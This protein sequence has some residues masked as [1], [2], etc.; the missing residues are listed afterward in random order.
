[1]LLRSKTLLAKHSPQA[2]FWLNGFWED[3]ANKYAEDIW[4]FVSIMQELVFHL[5]KYVESGQRK[6]YGK[7]KVDVRREEG[8]DFDF[9]G[10]KK[11]GSDRDQHNAQR[12]S[13]EEKLGETLT[14]TALRNR[15]KELDIDMNNKR[16]ISSVQHQ[17]IS[18]A[19]HNCKLTTGNE[20]IH[21]WL[22]GL[23][24]ILSQWGFLLFLPSRPSALSGC[25]CAHCH[26]LC[27]VLNQQLNSRSSK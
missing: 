4:N 15:L 21:A 20:E 2:R 22:Q 13:R 6:L 18:P 5:N 25:S 10:E 19:L 14:V 23:S 16:S 27:C 26:L 17:K 24:W 1:L 12:V 3:G 7:R 11:E 8:S 9:H